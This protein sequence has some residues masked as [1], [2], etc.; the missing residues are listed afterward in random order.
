MRAGAGGWLASRP[1]STRDRIRAVANASAFRLRDPDRE[2]L[3]LGRLLAR[4]SRATGAIDSLADVEF[5]VF[6]QWGDDGVIQWLLGNLALESDSFVEFGVA[7]YRE[8]TTRFL[9]MNDHWRGLVMDGDPANVEKIRRAEF[10]WRYE[11]ETVSA[12]ISRENINGLIGDAGFSGRIGLLH[13]DLDGNDYWVWEAVD[14]VDPDVVVMEYNAVLGRDR[15]ITV[16]YDAAFQRSAAHHSNLYFGASLGALD[17]LARRKGYALIGCTSAGNNAY[18]VRESLLNDR[19]QARTVEEAFV[20]S[21][22]R[23]S[24][25]RSG[26]LTYLSGPARIEAIRGL[27]V[28]DVTDGRRTT[29]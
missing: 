1:M 24:R 28:V 3:L 9:L 21:R 5:S 25:D 26:A 15:A 19:V 16:P 17:H 20:D 27:P 12:F 2:M 13:I 6:S 22:F 18:F 10:F 29:L 11:L 14:V 8:A 23:E 7:D 4:Q